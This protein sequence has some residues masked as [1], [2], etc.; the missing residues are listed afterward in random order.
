[1][2]SGRVREKKLESDHHKYVLKPCRLSSLFCNQSQIKK[3]KYL[4]MIFFGLIII[5]QSAFIST[6]FIDNPIAAQKD[7]LFSGLHTLSIH[8]KD[9]VIHDSLFHFL[10][11]KLKL[12]VYYYPVNMGERKYAGVYAGNL[13][14]EPCGPYSNFSY[15]TKNFKA[16]FFGLT[17]EPFKSLSLSAEGLADRG[18]HYNVDGDVFIYPVDSRV[19]GE[20][21]TLS[22]MEKHDKLNDRRILDSLRNNMSCGCKNELGIEYV[23]EIW[24]GYKDIAGLQTW[25]DLIEPSELVNNEIWK[26]S[27][28]L[29]I[30]FIRS[31]IKEVQRIV[32]KVKS[33]EKA[34]QYLSDNKLI[35]HIN[36]NEIEL[37]KEKTFGLSI[38]FAE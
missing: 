31:N 5:F 19:S 9:S 2:E 3:M 33:L 1:M 18:I 32:F 12:P 16:I 36:D 28:L 20:N 21:I 34:K 38:W 23:K 14:L 24:L 35:M 15:A 37:D 7:P 8:I 30:H 13:V 29:D 4:R 6:T 27:N 10:T 11:D 22:I 17:F 26:E 25:K